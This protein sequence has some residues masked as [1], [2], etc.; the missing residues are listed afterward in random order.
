MNSEIIELTEDVSGSPLYSADLAPVPKNKRTWNM[1]S[2]AALWVGMAVCIPTYILAS[3][4]IKSGLSW[5]ASLIIIGLANI[6]VTIPMALNGHVGVKYGIPFPVFGRASFGINGIHLV[7][8]LRAVVACGWFGVQTWIGG[9]AFYAIWNALTGSTGTPELSVGKFVCFGL[10]WL[11]NMYFIWKGTESIKWLENLSAPILILIGIVLIAWSA[12]K[13][14]GFGIVLDQGEQLGRPSVVMNQINGAITLQLNPLLNPDGSKKAAEFQV[15]VPLSDGSVK[16]L[17]WMPISDE[18]QLPED[19]EI[20]KGSVSS[21]KKTVQV[22]FRTG[23]TIKSSVVNVSITNLPDGSPN[24]LSYILW[25]TA[26]VGFWATMSLS[27]SDITRY[28]SRQKDQVAGQFLGLPG[29]MVLYSFVG[30]FVTCA[31]VINFKDI[32]IAD[33][34]PWDPVS[35][36]A[37]LDSPALV[38]VSQIFMIMATLT[39]NI[40]ANVIAPAN[41]FSNLSPKKISFFGGGVITGFI[42]IIICPWWLLNEIS[43]ILIFVSGALGPVLGILVCDYYLIRKTSL[44]LEALFRTDG[45]YAYG[46]RNFNS[47]AMIALAAGVFSALIGFWVPALEIFYHLSWFTGVLVSGGIYYLLMKSKIR[48]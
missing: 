3:Y 39:T 29:A 5:Q 17:D 7:S 16:S 20:N 40:A 31:T 4:M 10:F 11:V 28:A 34:A 43:S 13:A 47:S 12:N 22:Q 26:M 41:A 14:G 15:S 24:F 46:G 32:L 2:L 44:N 18:F 9:L 8:I 1:W 38:I 23:D 37:K 25:L 42:G 6:L 48:P 27:I 19:S 33:D 21:G 45:E 36:L 35:L 30:I